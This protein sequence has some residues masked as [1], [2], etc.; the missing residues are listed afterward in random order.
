DSLQS[1]LDLLSHP[2]VASLLS[3]HP[4]SLGLSSFARPTSWGT[5]WDWASMGDL[6]QD[7][8]SAISD[9][10]LI[11]LRHYEA[12][13]RG[14]KFGGL[15][16]SLG[17]IPEEIREIVKRLSDLSLPRHVGLSFPPSADPTY[18]PPCRSSVAFAPLQGMSPKKAHEVVEMT[19]FLETMLAS[20]RLLRHT[21]HAVD[22]GAG[23]AYL[24][25]NLRDRLG[26]HVLALDWSDIQTQGAARK[27]ASKSSRR[28]R[29]KGQTAEQIGTSDALS[30]EGSNSNNTS[31]GS[32]TY[33]TTCIDKESLLSSTQAWLGNAGPSGLQ[34]AS[35]PTHQSTLSHE[36]SATHV[37]LVGLH[38][39]G[40]LTLDILRAFVAAA[41]RS[42]RTGTSAS[43]EPA[44]W[45]PQGAV[46]VGCCY[47][48][49]RPEGKWP[50]PVMYYFRLTSNHL[51]LAAQVPAE[52]ARTEATLKD[53]RSALRKIVWRA[54]LEETL[55]QH[56]EAPA[57]H[58]APSVA[59]G[60]DGTH[61]DRRPRR[62]GRLNDSAY[63]DWE[64]FVHTV[65][66][67][68]G[69]ADVDMPKPDTELEK[70]IEV[71]HTLRCIAGP[72]VESL[73]LLD[74]LAWMQEELQGLPYKVELVNLFDQA[75]GSG[76]NVAIVIRP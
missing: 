29:Q 9:P 6:K 38:A 14:G 36:A 31:Q 63:K 49:M 51:Q 53:A 61:T 52:W 65:R 19:A 24:S 17:T 34:S 71:F 73:I 41:T 66:M 7:G 39:C 54:M 47:N 21:R 3:L 23:Q 50:K 30:N 8:S 58:E 74:R 27:D 72:A 60:D 67:K 25:R 10:W 37:L 44:S 55:T 12:C 5:W 20:N 62:L 18:L 76:R 59:C 15:F 28:S 16:E 57:H 4:N 1:I 13:R 56:A 68:L 11:L 33:V 48:M 35:L 42:L 32:L 46:I 2:L 22:I 75:S 64:T 40:S 26:V 43:P 69:L 70:R 45:I